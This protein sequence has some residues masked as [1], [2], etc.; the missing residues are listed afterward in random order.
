MDVEVTYGG[1]RIPNSP[2]PVDVS[3]KL[4]IEQVK[5]KGLDDGEC[6]AVKL[7]PAL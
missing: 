5:V 2:F 6:C 4:N 1:D 7:H 3:P